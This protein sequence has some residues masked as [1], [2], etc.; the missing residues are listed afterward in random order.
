MARRRWEV[1]LQAAFDHGPVRN[2]S[3]DGS[4]GGSAFG[5]TGFAFVQGERP[6]GGPKPQTSGSG[7][8]LFGPSLNRVA[9]VG[10]VLSEAVGS[11]AANAYDGQKSGDEEQQSEPL[12]QDNLM[13][14]HG[15]II[16]LNQE[17]VRGLSSVHPIGNFGVEWWLLCSLLPGQDCAPQSRGMDHGEGLAPNSAGSNT[18]PRTCKSTICCGTN[19]KI[20]VP[21]LLA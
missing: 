14:F 6:A 11:I 21:V 4:I 17:S 15:V 8:W 20:G 3:Q 2:G 19:P 7:W 1:R 16:E 9:G 13:S 18:L 5:W 10:N 12:N